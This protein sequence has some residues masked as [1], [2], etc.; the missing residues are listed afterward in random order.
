[1]KGQ[2]AEAVLTDV[3]CHTSEVLTYCAAKHLMNGGQ[4]HNYVLPCYS[5]PGLYAVSWSPT[6]HMAL[7]ITL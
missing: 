5:L 4:C 2:F 6:S 1:M 7:A 3:F